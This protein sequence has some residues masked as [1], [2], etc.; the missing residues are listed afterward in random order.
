[1]SGIW[2]LLAGLQRLLFVRRSR[3]DA[4]G[5]ERMILAGQP[6]WRCVSYP[7]DRAH[8]RE[9]KQGRRLSMRTRHSM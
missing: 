4:E 6:W 7:L 2:R 3:V 8:A 1:M 5:E 9:E